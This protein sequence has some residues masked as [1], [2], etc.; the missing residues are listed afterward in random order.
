MITKEM[1]YKVEADFDLNNSMCQSLA[2]LYQ[3]IIEADGFLLYFCL[4][5]LNSADHNELSLLM[6]KDL[7]SIERARYKLE[8]MGLLVTYLNNQLFLY[9]LNAP[10]EFRK[11]LYHDVFGRRLISVMGKEYY[12]NNLK[13]G[14]EIDKSDFVNVTQRPD[15]S[16]LNRW[17]D[18]QEKVFVKKDEVRKTLLFNQTQLFSGVSNLVFPYELRTQYN[19]DLIM[20]MADLYEIPLKKVK[21]IAF[22]CYDSATNLF[23]EE[24]FKS[25]VRHQKISR[26]PAHKYDLP[27]T[28]FLA[29]YQNSGNI[30]DSSAKILERLKNKY[31]FPNEVIN[32]IT[33]Y[34]L[35]NYN[36]DFNWGIMD[37]IGEKLER[38]KVTDYK[39][40]IEVI[41]TKPTSKA[42]KNEKEKTNDVPPWITRNPNSKSGKIDNDQY[43]EEEFEEAIKR[44]SKNENE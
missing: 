29:K 31:Y 20:E 32:V 40:A 43:S 19:I 16:F 25:R 33:E 2:L 17:N 21:E 28:Q 24:K 39:K 23:D 6:N 4:Y 8:E 22:N 13:K 30:A 37:K 36:M 14:A 44:L 11:F 3:P 18:N 5:N 41:N 10:L 7:P 1:K 12:Q 42:K 9:C 38:L 26:V 35:E 27:S 15:K 34:V